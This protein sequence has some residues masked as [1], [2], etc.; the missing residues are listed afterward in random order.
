MKEVRV[1][2]SRYAALTT[3]FI[4][5][6]VIVEFLSGNTTFAAFHDPPGPFLMIAEYGSGAIVARELAKKW[7]KGFASIF[8]LGAVYGMFNEGVGTGGF[9]DPDFYSV[10]EEGLKNYGR[11]E[12]I[13]VIWA[14]KIIL[15]HAVYSIAV[16]IV[17]VDGLFPAFANRRLLLGN[18]PLI[19]FVIVLVLITGFQRGILTHLQPPVNSY[20]FIAMIVIMLMLTLAAWRF[21]S[22]DRIATRRAP[23]DVTLIVS[24]LVGSFGWIV[25]IP[26]ILASI[27]LPILDVATLL[28]E[29]LLVSWLLLTL[30]DVSNRQWVALAAGAEGPL[31]AHAATSALFVPAAI[32]LALLVAAWRNSGSQTGRSTPTVHIELF[33]PAA[34]VVAVS[35]AVLIQSLFA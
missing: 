1:S 15:F 34:L 18:K 31:L 21:P 30:A 17:I 25:V 9:F 27:H 11:W 10:V 24:G 32:T 20:A 26:R 23:S 19:A 12:G 2:P 8:I 3:L 13:N 14:L 22:F 5:P 7:R 16:P 28:C 35:T 29:V 33:T 4:V 6:S